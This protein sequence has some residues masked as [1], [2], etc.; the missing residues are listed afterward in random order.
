M[1]ARYRAM[2]GRIEFEIEGATAKEVFTQIA[3]AQEVFDAEHSCG[4]CGSKDIKFS[5]RESEG[6]K[7]GKAQTY[8][9][10]ELRCQAVLAGNE[11]CR[12]RFDFGQSLDTENLFP[13]RTKPDPGTNENV[14]MPNRGWYRYVPKDMQGQ[15]PQRAAAPQRM[16]DTPTAGPSTRFA[17]TPDGLQPSFDRL[18]ELYGWRQSPTRTGPALDQ[19]RN[20]FAGCAGEVGTKAFDKLYREYSAKS[21]KGTASAIKALLKECVA[22]MESLGGRQVA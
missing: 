18:A 1:K 13:K 20:E 12:G 7:N 9:Y 19:L 17:D 2:E 11:P 10:Y 14:R 3:E 5:V 6:K 8:T 22:T 21:D 4:L 15:E 16:P